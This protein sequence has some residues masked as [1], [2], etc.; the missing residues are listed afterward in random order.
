MFIEAAKCLYEEHL[1]YKD[2]SSRPG[3]ISS[4]TNNIKLPKPA[5]KKKKDD[6]D[7]DVKEETKK[8]GCC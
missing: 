4:Q 3:S 7:D 5:P 8:G 2:R 6:D 1:K